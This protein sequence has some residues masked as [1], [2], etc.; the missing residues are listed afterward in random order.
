[1]IN[2][3]VSI[4][5]PTYNNLNF[6][7][8]ALQSCLNQTYRKIEIIIVD[9]GSID[10]TEDW[11]KEQQE[12]Y[13]SIHYIKQGNAGGG[14]ARNKGLEISS[15]E[16]IQFLDSD[17]LLELD[18]VEQAVAR[19]ND[20]N[21]LWFCD[22]AS[23]TTDFNQST[24]ANSNYP[25]VLAFE[26]LIHQ[27]F[28]ATP[29]TLLPKE[30]VVAVGGFDTKLIRGQEQDLYMRLAH[31]GFEFK[32]FDYVGFYVRHHN[33][34]HRI[35]NFGKNNSVENALY[36]LKKIDG[37]IANYSFYEKH[38]KCRLELLNLAFGRSQ[39]HA[40]IRDWSSVKALNNF[41]KDYRNKYKLPNIPNHYD[42]WLKN[43]LVRCLGGYLF[44]FFR[45]YSK[46]VFTWDSKVM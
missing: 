8:D 19:I 1:M 45:V 30:Q 36:F 43:I 35:S 4:I 13:S 28:V 11:I 7:P 40:N 14:A 17:D 10:G 27:Y 29:A 20:R 23:F 12:Y 39:L 22:S 37:L 42:H 25:P 41:A 24:P 32:F 18:K 31:K 34:N 26:N 15:G 9:D 5:I 44:E 33:S 38:Q 2:P 16:Y 21:I 46:A 3:L 6:L